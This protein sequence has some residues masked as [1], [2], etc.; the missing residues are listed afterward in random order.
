MD[1]GG[2]LGSEG[3]QQYEQLLSVPP[4]R[5]LT[6]GV[7][8]LDADLAQ[9]Q[10]LDLHQYRRLLLVVKAWEPPMAELLDA[11]APLASLD[12]CTVLLLPLPGKPTPRR[13]VED[14]HAFARRLPFASVDVQLLNRVVD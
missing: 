14:W 11:L 4:G 2:G 12:R 5:Q 13:K 1:Y 6:I 3:P 7:A 9:L 8:A 10:T